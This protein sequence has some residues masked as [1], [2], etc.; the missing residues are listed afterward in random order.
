MDRHRGNER[1]KFRPKLAA[2]QFAGLLLVAGYLDE[3]MTE[4][5]VRQKAAELLGEFL[6]NQSG[7]EREFNA[8]VRTEVVSNPNSKWVGN[9]QTKELIASLDNLSQSQKDYVWFAYNGALK[10]LEEGGHENPAGIVGVAILETGYGTDALSP[11]SN[12]HFG[13]KG[14]GDAGTVNM[15]TREV[16]NGQDAYIVDGFKA[17]GDAY[18]SFVDF[19]KMHDRLAHY[20][21]VAYCSSTPEGMLNAMQFELDLN[22][23]EILATQGE[24]S[25]VTDTVVLGHATDPNYVS[26]VM[27]VINSIGAEQFFLP[28]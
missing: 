4:G 23:C 25:P 28:A 24:M 11:I 20:A 17:Y 13:I 5:V 2:A 1:K 19:S 15:Q 18:G 10:V 22:T 9:P 21:D 6:G 27:D 26:A 16:L 3:H 8:P 14:V 12:N 7:Q